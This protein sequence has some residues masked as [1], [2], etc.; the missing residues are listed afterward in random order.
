MI[1][2]LNAGK[3][4]QLDWIFKGLNYEF[5]Q[6]ERYAIVG[7]NGSGKSTLINILSGYSSLTTGDC[8]WLNHNKSNIYKNIAICA[9]YLNVFEQLTAYEFLTFHFQLKNKIK[10]IEIEQILYDVELD[11][12]RNKKISQ[13][14]NGMKQRIKLAQAFFTNSQILL[15]DEPCTN[16]DKQGIFLYENLI[17][18]YTNQRLLIIASNDPKE[19]NYCTQT[20]TLQK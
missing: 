18:N 20:L 7:K 4:F 13:F 12:T 3:R 8:I 15:L 17:Q 10:N 16:L 5:K 1:Q 14:S 2:L 6:Q 19:T 9:P 11:N